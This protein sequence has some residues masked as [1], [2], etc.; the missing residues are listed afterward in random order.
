MPATDPEKVSD[1]ANSV[2][3]PFF[4]E[5]IPGGIEYGSVLLVEFEPQSCWYEAAYTLAAQAVQQGLKTD[6]HIF[7]HNPRT[8]REAMKG[9]G[10]D[11]KMLEDADLL[12]F[13][14]SYSVQVGVG[15][16]D[17]PKGADAFKTSSVKLEDWAKAAA[18]QM[19]AE[20]PESEKNRVHIDDST[21][22]LSRYN[23][24]DELIDYWRTRSSQL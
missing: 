23:D 19:S 12:R 7:Q 10:L 3:I 8:V 6:L 14:D 17:V 16:A 5:L 21:A 24:E 18:A 15:K 2:H 1:K 9:F 13:I 20:I 22:I 11:V 4:S